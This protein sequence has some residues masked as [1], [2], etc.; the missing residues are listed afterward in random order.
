MAKVASLALILLLALSLVL[1][2][3]C[4]TTEGGDCD[5]RATHL[6]LNS[7]VNGQMTTNDFH[8][9]FCV[10]APSGTSTLTITLYNMNE[11]LD[12]LIFASYDDFDDYLFR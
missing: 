8:K 1:M 6:P 3:G 4:T 9:M 7:A 5:S 2:G 11:D 12:L 10:F